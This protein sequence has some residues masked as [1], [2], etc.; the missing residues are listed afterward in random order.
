MSI[1]KKIAPKKKKIKLIKK[2]KI[3]IKRNEFGDLHGIDEKLLKK[4]IELKKKL[5]SK[6][7]EICQYFETEKRK[8]DM[9]EERKLQEEKI[10]KIEYMKKKEEYEKMKKLKEFEEKVK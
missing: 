6:K 4:K 10:K 1:H 3:K 5:N 8:M 9:M 2:K 7:E